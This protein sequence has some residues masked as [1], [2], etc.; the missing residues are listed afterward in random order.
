[1][2]KG[3]GIGGWRSAKRCF[4]FFAA[5]LSI[6][7]LI[8]SSAF[9]HAFLEHAEPRVGSTVQSSPPTL[10]LRFTEP[11]EL[12]FCRVELRDAKGQGMEIGAL[13]QPKPEELR[14]TLP[15]LS[16]GDYTVHW[17]VTSVDTHQT[18]GN[19]DFTVAAP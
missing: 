16:V 11:V 14:V 18:E 12:N 13:E 17:A 7:S 5:I 6:P 8:V 2:T 1:M 15:P 3:L 4:I 9:A 19:F 10:T